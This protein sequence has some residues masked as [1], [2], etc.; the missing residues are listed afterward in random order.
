MLLAAHKIGASGFDDRQHAF[1]KRAELDRR[2]LGIEIGLV[3]IV[4]VGFRE[5]ITRVGERRHPAAVL[6][7]RVP[8][9]MIVMQVRAHHEVDLLRP[10]AGRGEPLK[11]GRV[12][13]APPRPRR[14]HAIV[15]A[16]R[17]DQD[18]LPADLKQPAM[19]AE[20][21]LGGRGIV[22]I[23]RQPM[24]MLLVDLVGEF[25]K[26]LLRIVD[27]ADRSPRSAQR[28]PCPP[29]TACAFLADVVCGP[30]YFGRNSFVKVDGKSTGTVPVG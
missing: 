7:L 24:R 19:H 25:R 18:L 26:Q 13:H 12:E 21:D 2:G 9:D 8:A 16:A 17:V 10:R 15:A 28:S 23:W 22:V 1:A 30:A 6:H 11:P 3:E 5:H 4:H 29:K 20:F 14:P 27:R